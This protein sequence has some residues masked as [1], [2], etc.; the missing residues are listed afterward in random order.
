MELHWQIFTFG[1]LVFFYFLM[2]SLSKFAIEDDEVCK[3]L[4]SFDSFKLRTLLIAPW[5]LTVCSHIANP[6]TTFI[7]K[8][9]LFFATNG[10]AIFI[11]KFLLDAQVFGSKTI[12]GI[13]LLYVRCNFQLLLF[14]IVIVGVNW[15]A[16]SR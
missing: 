3:K 14:L 13:I 5:Y 1:L 16:I 2:L 4:D 12:G 7:E 10:A 6:E 8:T 15:C 11:T 9:L